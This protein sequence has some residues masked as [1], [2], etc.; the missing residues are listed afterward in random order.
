MA[1]TDQLTFRVYIGTYTQG[2]S[3]G[4]YVY[5]FDGSTGSWQLQSVT[6]D[7]QSPAF[8]AIHP[9]RRFLYAVNEV[10]DFAGRTSGAVSAYAIEDATGSL[11]RLNQQASMGPGPCHLSVDPTGRCVLVANYG[12]GSVALLPIN[13]DGSLK[14]A[15][16]FI[17]HEG[18]GSDPKR[19]TAPHAHSI[20][21]DPQGRFALAADLG[22]DKIMIYELDLIGGKLMAHTP[23]W[24]ALRPGAGPRHSVF[25]SNGRFLYVINEL[26]ST[27]TVFAYRAEEGELTSLQTVSTLPT[28]FSETNYCADIHIHPSGRYLYGSNRGHDSI[29]SYRVDPA[30]GLLGATAHYSTHGRTPRGFAIDPSGA[31]LVA[32]NQDSDNIVAFRIDEQTGALQLHGEPTRVPSPV[33]VKI[34]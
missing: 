28:G 14:E 1:V 15:T 4:I 13:E 11:H 30:T 12:G 24:A 23:P 6:P 29:V 7:Q 20:L 26:D 22:L 27:I 16:C 32:A 25:H 3:K 19:Q 8:L 10:R 9:N 34:P 5:R 33:C 17:Q 21:C 2:E 18:R 31:F